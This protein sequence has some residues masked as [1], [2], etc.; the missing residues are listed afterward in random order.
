MLEVVAPKMR[1]KI[2]DLPKMGANL[3]KM[4]ACLL[5]PGGLSIAPLP[6]KPG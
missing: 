4:E 6:Y 3:P 2:C 5:L 1:S